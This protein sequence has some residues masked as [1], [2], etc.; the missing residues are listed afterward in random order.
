MSSSR[1]PP[2]RGR[3]EQRLA[4]ITT[5][6]PWRSETAVIK[7]IHELEKLGFPIHVFSLK[8]TSYEGTF[9]PKAYRFRDRTHYPGPAV[10]LRSLLLALVHVIFR[11]SYRRLLGLT[12]RGSGRH[13]GKNLY[14]LLLLVPEIAR[15]LR[16]DGTAYIHANFASYQAFAALGVHRLTGIPYG[17]TVHAHDIFL[18][19]CFIPEKVAEAA[20]VVSI[21]RYNVDYMK[22]HFHVSPQK[23]R[24][25]H[26]GVD[27]AEF[28]PAGPP[29][30]GL[31]MILSVGRM[32]PM[33]GFDT[34]LDACAEL[35]RQVAFR[36]VLVGSGP[37]LGRLQA[38]AADLQ[39]E[40]MVEFR[41]GVPQEELVALYR[42][43][44]LY[45]QPCRQTSQGMQDG[46]P[47]TLM[48]AMAV[49]K[50]TVST[51]VSGIPEL[52]EDGVEGRLVQPEDPAALC[53]AMGELLEDPER[54]RRMGQAGRK[55]IEN[56]FNIAVS[57]REL[58]ALLKE[59][60]GENSAGG[61]RE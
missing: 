14:I 4:Y 53:S 45:V 19:S 10:W 61:P 31:P 17:F 1:R 27:L 3:Q 5:A 32:D 55:R 34:L 56:E 7:E 33:K 35:R 42:D 23:L 12:L 28:S 59:T 52:I 6:F 9:D 48:E 18:D 36:C 15:R 49:A 26:C 58:C 24:V 25:V 51:Y 39:L 2:A 57:A 21:S 29:P 20:L 46:I 54:C 8:R 44:H 40:S 30:A 50:P 16:R 13:L 37:E 22:R 38:R 47:A 43:C 11:S 60:L 41:S